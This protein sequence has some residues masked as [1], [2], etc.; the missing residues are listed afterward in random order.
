[1]NKKYY[2][3]EELDNIEATLIDTLGVEEVYKNLTK[4]LGYETL[5]EFL[6]DLCRDYDINV[7]EEGEKEND[8]N[9]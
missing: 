1:M 6:S 7:D 4:W 3:F 2:S 9:N 5:G 8:N